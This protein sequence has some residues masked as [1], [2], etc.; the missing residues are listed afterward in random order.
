MKIRVRVRGGE[1]GG[2]GNERDG[3][4]GW[5]KVGGPGEKEGKVK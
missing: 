4:V 5:L 1:K 3:E 2:K